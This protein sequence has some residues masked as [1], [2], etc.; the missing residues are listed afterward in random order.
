MMECLRQSDARALLVSLLLKHQN[1]KFLNVKQLSDGCGISPNRMSLILQEQ[2]LQVS[3]DIDRLYRTARL[4]KIARGAAS[5]FARIISFL[6]KNKLL[7]EKSKDI[8]TPEDLL[9]AYWPDR[10]GAFLTSSTGKLAVNAGIEDGKREEV[11]AKPSDWGAVADEIA[12]AVAA[13][14]MAEIPNNSAF[15]E[16][17][18]CALLEKIKAP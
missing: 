4:T 8:L 18:A 17:L 5:T 13:K 7:D 9:Y 3:D 15:I 11:T 2:P 1:E 10:H 16:K 14:I 6:D 12:D